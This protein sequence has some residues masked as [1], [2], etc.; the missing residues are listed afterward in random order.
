MRGGGD[1]Q[2]ALWILLQNIWGFFIRNYLIFALIRN[3]LNLF[4]PMSVPFMYP[5]KMSVN[6]RFS[7]VFKGY[8]NGTLA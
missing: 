5:L 8:R 7:D 4:K 1:L 6:P 3:Y 2:P